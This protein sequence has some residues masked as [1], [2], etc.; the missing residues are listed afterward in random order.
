M[1]N[2][3]HPQG[4]AA[5]VTG[6]AS[7]EVPL[8]SV[9]ELFGS[10]QQGAKHYF[11]PDYQRGYRWE[12]REV[13]QLLSDLYEFMCNPTEQA[14]FYCLQ[15]LVVIARKGEALA[16][17]RLEV[18]HETEEVYEVVDGQQRLTTLFLLVKYFNE[19]YRGK[20]KLTTPQL[21]FETRPKSAEVLNGIGLDGDKA[22][23]ET[24]DES[25]K[26]SIDFWHI[27]RA[28]EYIHEWCKDNVADNLQG[29][30]QDFV[31]DQAKFIWY[32]V[33]GAQDAIKVFERNNV[34]KIALTD[35]ELIKA[36]L[37]LRNGQGDAN[38]LRQQLETAREWDEMERAL[39][40]TS[41]W[42][43]LYGG[44]KAP[45]NRLEKLFDLV[46]KLRGNDKGK[47]FDRVEAYM[48]SQEV[49]ASKGEAVQTYPRL[50]QLWSKVKE[51]FSVFTDWHSDHVF[52]HYV[53]YL[54]S[55]DTSIEEIWKLSQEY[56]SM[57]KEAFK[58]VLKGKIKE[59]VTKDFHYYVSIGFL[60]NQ[61]NKSEGK[62]VYDG[63]NCYS[64]GKAA[65][66]L[67]L[68][69]NV[70][71]CLRPGCFERLP[72]PLYHAKAWDMEHIDSQTENELKSWKDQKEWL[73]DVQ[74][75]VQENAE[76][77]AEIKGY[78]GKDKADEET[79]SELR[80]KV[81]MA[82]GEEDD[83]YSQSIGNLCLLDATTNRSYQN[84][85]FPVKRE[86]IVARDAEGQYIFP[87]T[88]VAFMKFFKDAETDR[89]TQ[90]TEADK[91][92]YGAH[93]YHMIQD[94][95]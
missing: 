29:S 88:R 22:V 25:V 17:L 64:K 81:Q 35:A 10:Q 71:L 36:Q 8:R 80:G 59:R 31:M 18:P 30:F 82:L 46:L 78:L 38:A 91:E 33:D 26:Q 69:Y 68:L 60:V 40:Q 62:V 63:E 50:E 77:S 56:A 53:G 39:R 79:F 76:L 21:H 95:L 58:E 92:A 12:K 16:K 52:Y 67:Q 42:T 86:K 89:V 3:V 90:W 28:Y 73:E 48:K 7:T 27:Q 66:D 51:M 6:K 65:K 94:F 45:V 20:N 4:S 9:R 23:F 49:E 24:T 83:F 93:I 34:G 87:G 54:T 19:Q 61:G 57:T 32:A 1:I 74:K 47:L 75:F 14:N 13:T 15:P 37:L 70:Q 41:L 43:F 5:L 44:E 84:A 11:I 2:D 85:V 55:T 72:F